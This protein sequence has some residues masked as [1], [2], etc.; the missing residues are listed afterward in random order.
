M[1]RDKR[2]IA[3]NIIIN[4]VISSVLVS[5][6]WYT[7]R[8]IKGPLDMIG[9]ILFTPAFF[10]LFLLKGPTSAMHF[11]TYNTYLVVGFVFYSAAIALIQILFYKRRRKKRAEVE[12]E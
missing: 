12:H 10:I 9:G 7:G 6:M 1:L 3:Q 4:I 5:L 11:T 8:F 2:F